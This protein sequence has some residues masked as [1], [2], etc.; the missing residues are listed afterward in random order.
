[1]ASVLTIGQLAKA[2]GVS[3]RT[4]RFYEQVGALPRPGRSAAGYR[5]YAPETA[6]RLAFLRRARSLGLSL[7]ELRVR[8]D[9]LTSPSN[10]SFRPRLRSVV[11]TQ[12]AAVRQRLEDLRTL[13]GQ[14][15]EV[16]RHLEA[17]PG[18]RVARRPGRCDC[19]DVRTTAR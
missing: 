6:D 5:Q 9:A 19:L 1:M 18:R 17:A 4:I 15:E 8:G 3:A 11:R 2:T 16:V 10:G 14:L 13:E 12:L 7:R